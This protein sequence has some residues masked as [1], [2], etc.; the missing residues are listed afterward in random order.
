MSAVDAEIHLIDRDLDGQREPLSQAQYAQRHGRR[1]GL[2]ALEE[3]GHELIRIADVELQRQRAKY[4]GAAE[5]VP[6]G[7]T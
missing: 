7:I 2:K 5:T 1:G 3:M 6:E 4:E